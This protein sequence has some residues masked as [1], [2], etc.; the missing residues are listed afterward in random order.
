MKPT[1]TIA[2]AGLAGALLALL[3]ARRG[4]PVEVIERRADPRRA[5]YEGGRSINLALAERGLHGLR[6]AG[7]EDLVMR[8]AVMMRGRM[9]HEGSEPY[10]QR[11]GKDDGEVIW[12]VNRGRL[13]ISLL[14]AAEAAGA[15]LRFDA[16]LAGVDWQRRRYRI[17]SAAG[18]V[19]EHEFHALIG[20]DGAG[21]ALRAAMNAKAPLGERFEPLGHGYKELSIAALADGGFR[22]ERNALHIWPRGGYMLIALPNVDGSFTVT[23]FLP[24]EGDPSFAKLTD[25][26]AV[27][28]FFAQDFPDAVP[29]LPRL[30]EEFAGNPTGLLGTLRLDHWHLDGDALLIGDAAHAMVPFH[31]QGMNCAFEDSVELDTLLAESDDLAWVFGE[32]QA[33]RRPNAQAIAD[34]ALENYVEMRDAVA[35]DRYQLMKQVERLLAARH[36]DRFV[37][38][39][40][41][42]SFRRVPYAQA[43]ARGE[44]QTKLLR[45]LTEGIQHAD[46]IDLAVADR[47][48]A[49]EL[50]PL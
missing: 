18:A 23:L 4:Q 48:I 45:D 7:L 12:S 41:M 32:L 35:D 14:D 16:R 36:P 34:M 8:Q 22:I 25:D 1:L 10:L 9:I 2:G 50:S 30:T 11:Y 20:A 13:N 31:G 33:R 6:I 19:H 3:L 15:R 46:Q 40:T 24:N 17:E 21:S 49:T 42:V 44:I 39:Y 43:R 37:P 28:A 29:L 5:G 47:R 27:A 38:R 26:R